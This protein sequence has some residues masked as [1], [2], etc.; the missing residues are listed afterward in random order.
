MSDKKQPNR[1]AFLG[2]TAGTLAAL[3]TAPAFVPSTVLGKNAPSGRV[4]VGIIGLGSRGMDHVR[5]SFRNPQIRIAAIADLD[6]TFL[7]GCLEFLDTQMETNRRWTVRDSW[8]TLAGPVSEGAVEPYLD[9]RRLLER[10]DLDGVLVAVPDHWHAKT[11]IDAMDAGLDV[12][13]EKPF[14]LAIQQGRKVV[15][16][17]KE[18]GRVFQTGFQQR[19]HYNFQRA[20]EVIRNGKLGKIEKIVTRVGATPNADPVPDEPAPGGLNWD[21]WLGPA[22]KVPY[23]SMRCHVNFRHFFEYA[24]GMVTDIGA[25]ETDIVQW[26]LDMDHSGPRYI[27]GRAKRAKGMFNTFSDFEFT[28]TYENGAQLVIS[29][30]PGFDMRFYGEK[31]EMFL[32][33]AAIRTNPAEILDEKPGPNDLRFVPEGKQAYANEGESYHVS[34]F[35]HIQNWVD[36][37]KTRET[38]IV[39][40]EIGQRSSTVAHLANIC[41][42]VG[43]RKLEWDPKTEW[44][45]NDPE[46][47]Q[48]LN[49]PQREPHAV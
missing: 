14:T 33:R 25:H 17:C 48:L 24:G 46:A 32:N 26:A 36:C 7:M 4:N 39:P 49:P 13:G 22:P 6:M 11:Y 16:K 37:I 30:D 19:S 8:K 18:T 20:C 1:R 21:L 40:A 3:G 47:N 15:E 35:D 38:P 28:L 41:G 42:L 43:G 12:Y 9:Y 23:N 5:E 2:K 31:G 10:K 34:T 44:F 27:E 29:S 45:V